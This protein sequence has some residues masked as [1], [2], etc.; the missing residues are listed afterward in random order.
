MIEASAAFHDASNEGYLDWQPASGTCAQNAQPGAMNL[1]R[2]D[3]G[4]WVYLNSGSTSVGLAKTN[5]TDGVMYTAS[6]LGLADFISNASYDVSVPDGGELGD[7]FDIKNAIVTPQGFTEIQP[8]ELLL[9]NPA[10]AFSA[11]VSASGTSWTIRWHGFYDP[12]GCCTRVRVM[13]NVTC[14][15]PITAKCTSLAVILRVPI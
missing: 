13:G 2:R 9:V 10:A 5:G 1:T 4:P 14:P 12:G 3:V 8:Y 15:D 11:A 6:N 7:G